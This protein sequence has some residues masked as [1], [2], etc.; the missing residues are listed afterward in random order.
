MHENNY[1]DSLE[2]LHKD[3]HY[4]LEW[5]DEKADKITKHLTEDVI[6]HWIFQCMNV[7]F[8]GSKASKV[9]RSATLSW[10]PSDTP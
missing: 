3:V 2:D 5:L 8:T 7:M 1:S 9:I 10:F 4:L 6:Q